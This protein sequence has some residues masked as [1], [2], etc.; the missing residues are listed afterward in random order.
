[1]RQRGRDEGGVV[2]LRLSSRDR[3]VGHDGGEEPRQTV[4]MVFSHQR[5]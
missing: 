2:D 1:M 5:T 4:R 3:A